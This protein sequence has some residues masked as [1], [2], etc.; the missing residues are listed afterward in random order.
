MIWVTAH[1]LSV[2]FAHVDLYPL[3]SE[4][5]RGKRS[6]IETDIRCFWYSLGEKEKYEEHFKMQP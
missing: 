2:C 4:L 1:K 3:S 5:G 6:M